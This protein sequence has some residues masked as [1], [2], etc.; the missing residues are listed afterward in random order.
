[1]QNKKLTTG[2]RMLC[3]VLCVSMLCG[4]IPAVADVTQGS[5]FAPS[6]T[7]WGQQNNN[8][9]YYLY[10]GTDGEYHQL[11]YYSSTASI[12]WQRNAFAFDPSAMNEMLFISKT[13]FFTGENGSIPAYG[14]RAPA[15]GTIKLTFQ[16]HGATDM[17]MRVL[18]KRT[19][20]SINGNT[21]LTLN[22]NGYTTHTVELTVKSG[23]WIYLEGYTVGSNREGWVRNY[24]VTYQ[25]VSQGADANDTVYEPNL[26]GDWGMQNNNGWYYMYQ[27]R[28]TGT[29]NQMPFIA[30]NNTEEN[31]KNCF[32]ADR[33][34]PYCFITRDVIHPATSANAVKA[35]CAPMGGTVKFELKLKRSAQ[36][37]S[38]SPSCFT[39]YQGNT[40]IYPKDSAYKQINYRSDGSWETITITCDVVAGEWI[41]FVL[42]CNGSNINGEVQMQE[43]ATYTK[44]NNAAMPETL[45]VPE[46]EG[47]QIRTASAGYDM[48][49]TFSVDKTAFG[50]MGKTGAYTI[51]ELGTIWAV[52]DPNK[53]LDLNTG[54][55]VKAT[56]LNNEVAGQLQFSQTISGISK[57]K[58]KTTYAVRPYVKVTIHGVSH[59]FYGD[60]AEASVY[61]YLCSQDTAKD[62]LKMPISVNVS[63]RTLT[64]AYGTLTINKLFVTKAQQNKTQMPYSVT[65]SGNTVTGNL[66][67]G[68]VAIKVGMNADGSVSLTESVSK[69]Q[70]G[71]SGVSI[72]LQFSMDYD[73]ILPAWGGVRLTKENPNAAPFPNDSPR[74]YIE[75][76]LE[77]DA[78]MFLIQGE[79]GGYLVYHDDDGSQ[80]KRLWLS[81]DGTNFNFTLETVPQAPFDNY[82]SFEAKPWV[83]VAYEGDWT[84]GLELYKSFADAKFNMDQINAQKPDWVDDIQGMVLADLDAGGIPA[85]TELA[86][87]VDPS[88]VVVIVPGWRQDL[89]DVNYPNYTAKAG[90]KENIK[91]MQA[92]GYKIFLHVNFIGCDDEAVEY[93]QY[94]LANARYLEAYSKEPRLE[95][96]TSTY[97]VS[98][99][100]LN[101]ANTTWQDLLVQRLKAVYDELGVDGFHLDQS[102]LCYNDGRGYVN[103]MTSMQG[104]VEL[105][106]KL[107]EALPNC[108]F[109]GEG[110]NEINCRYSSFLQRAPYGINS[111]SMTAGW[112]DA[113][114]EQI[115]PVDSYLWSGT[116]R[117]YHYPAMPP[118]GQE[119]A[120]LAWTK[121]GIRLGALP[122][123]MR[124]SAYELINQNLATEEAIAL[125]RW[126]QENKPVF[127][128]AGWNGDEAF[129]CYRTARGRTVMFYDDALW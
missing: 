93:T 30:S 3:L 51:T 77:W 95:S 129:L 34:Y 9:W 1:M 65:A 61:D 47:F 38:G 72:G 24:S 45:P 97:S 13:S 74:A 50:D 54:T 58:E 15:G 48:R 122:T 14:F 56:Y 113:K 128:Y 96:W 76:P 124:S 60:T 5:V 99:W 31:F 66:I 123:L 83:I 91:K 70:S 6:D 37:V 86:K 118:S 110:T 92:L 84:N 68:S 121:A 62:V 100:M 98:F 111:S 11:S 114:V 78:Q 21:E 57:S 90:I 28:L 88:Q 115:L 64:S 102:L 4:L 126:Y 32:S 108:A 104:N 125:F 120:Y 27:D 127:N 101:P 63:N 109:S 71:I 39:V 75:Y 80:F 81:N 112:S 29:Y 55:V 117:L 33:A 53:E 22:T 10:K 49:F 67:D 12:S 19:A 85:L 2:L 105:Q 44:V 35:F 7:L 107:A 17:R 40:K 41:Y 103:G 82:T 94:G 26:D 87:H 25:T 42:G 23:D 119:E 106:K 16:T 46:Y 73:V 20:V 18:H 43:K 69:N 59:V 8:N 89:Y 116:T 52:A 36:N 79:K